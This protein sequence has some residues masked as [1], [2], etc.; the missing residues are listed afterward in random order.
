MFWSDA[1]ASQQKRKHGAAGGG[2]RRVNAAPLSPPA[3]AHTPQRRGA[4]L[5]AEENE[6]YV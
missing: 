4:R 5:D 2:A 3:C 6:S 1:G